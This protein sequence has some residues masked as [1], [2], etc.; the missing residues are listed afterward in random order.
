MLE[1]FTQCPAHRHPDVTKMRCFALVR[2][3]RGAHAAHAGEWPAHDAKN[4]GNHDGVGIAREPEAAFG[5]SLTRHEPPTTKIGEDR[6]EELR[7][8]FLFLGE[9]LGAYRGVARGECEE[10][11]NRVLGLRGNLHSTILPHAG[12]VDVGQRQTSKVCS[13]FELSS[14][15]L[16]LCVAHRDDM[17]S[18]LP[19]VLR[20]G[21]DVVQLREKDLPDEI[22]AATART[23]VPICHEFGVP[24]IMND[25]PE[26]AAIVGADG[27]HVGQDDATVSHCREVLGADAIVG[28]S[29]HSNE[30]FDAALGQSTTYFSAGPIV[31]TPTKLGRAG[32]GVEYATRSQ[33]KS[34][35]PVFVTGGVT[36]ENVADLIGEGLRHFV[37]VRYLTN[38]AKPFE[39]ARALRD[40][41]DN[42]LSAVTVKPT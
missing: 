35:R 15:N 28:L 10:G 38:A 20:G 21:V 19:E 36:N 6:S 30:E 8:E 24:F 39:A 9:V 29:T 12:P 25:S 37:V 5:A 16:Y 26:L 11:P 17:G 33:R 3:C 41:I 1:H 14:R 32:T 34:D 2:E 40:A 42:A 18:F 23:M 13:V 22:R 7:R 31:E 4:V 27:V